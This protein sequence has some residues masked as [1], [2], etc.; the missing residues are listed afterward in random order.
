MDWLSFFIG[1]LFG[2]II[3]WLID[4]FFLEPRRVARWQE[5]CNI[6]QAQ[7][8]ALKTENTRI[9]ELQNEI[10]E[11]RGRLQAYESERQEMAQE[12]ESLSVSL[13]DAKH[14]LELASGYAD[15]GEEVGDDG[16]SE[17]GFAAPEVDMPE[18]VT[19]EVGLKAPDIEVEAPE[20]EG[21]EFDME[22][23]ATALTAS[24]V[25]RGESHE[26]AK[27]PLQPDDLR[28]I[29][30]IGPKIAQLLND[31]GIFTFAQLAEADV[32]T[33][34]QILANAGSRFRLASPETWPEQ[35]RLAANGAWDAL[36][37]L[38]ENLK[39]GRRA[40]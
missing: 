14:K 26:I 27:E 3:E 11:L 34:R 25:V 10:D 19:P 32:D 33:L 7:N 37:S 24:V 9:Q 2:W 21:Y 13:A 6:L 35:A 5:R 28:I 17:F 15:M 23:D 8:A 36:E 20:V 16:I 1:V 22:V 39:G 30:G 38:Q 40:S 31:A 12:I 4:H 29:E 18:T